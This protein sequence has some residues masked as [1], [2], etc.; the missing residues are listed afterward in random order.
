MVSRTKKKTACP[1]HRNTEQPEFTKY[2]ILMC[3][4]CFNYPKI[5]SIQILKKLRNFNV[6]IPED[7]TDHKVSQ[8]YTLIKKQKPFITNVLLSSQQ[9]GYYLKRLEE[10]SDQPITGADISRLL[11][12][13]QGL[14]GNLRY[15]PEGR[16]LTNAD[17]MISLMR[18]DEESFKAYF[19]FFIAPNF[20]KLFPFPRLINIFG[21]NKAKPPNDYVGKTPLWERYEDIGDYLLAYQAYNRAKNQYYVDQG[22]KPPSVL[23][24]GFMEKLTEKIDMVATRYSMAKMQLNPKRMIIM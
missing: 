6:I 7:F 2:M 4:I 5:Q 8:I 21:N 18:G 13:I 15:V 11:D 24:P 16:F 1:I 17:V 22:L 23:E 9:G 3:F 20:Y 14:T 19:K 12:E 10:K